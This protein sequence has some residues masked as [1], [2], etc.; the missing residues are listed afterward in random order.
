MGHC[1]RANAV[2]RKR[3]TPSVQARIGPKMPSRGFCLGS[4]RWYEGR[5]PARIRDEGALQW[6]GHEH[7]F[8]ACTVCTVQEVGNAVRVV[9]SDAGTG[10]SSRRQ[11]GHWIC[12][13]NPLSSCGSCDKSISDVTTCTNSRSDACCT[14]MPRYGCQG[15][16]RRSFLAVAVPCT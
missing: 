12:R 15:L 5:A 1:V 2:C 7:R 9:G 11:K 13:K 3:N 6:F 16:N 4:N 14:D 8:V 10:V